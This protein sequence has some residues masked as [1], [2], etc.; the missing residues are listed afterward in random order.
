V[1]NGSDA[2]TAKARL[3][4]PKERD[5]LRGFFRAFGEKNASSL[6]NRDSNFQQ[7]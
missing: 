4:S 3:L 6:Q 2:Q 5:N 1:K 7:G